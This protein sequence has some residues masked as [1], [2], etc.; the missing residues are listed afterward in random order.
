MTR[1]AAIVGWGMAVP[2]RVVTNADIEQLVDTSD[3]WIRA[4]TGIAERRIA[5][6]GVPTSA[7]ASAAGREALERAGVS[8]ESVDLVVLAT[9]TPDRLFP[10]TASTVQASLGLPNAGAFD[11]VAACSGFVYGLSVA[12]SMVQSGAHETVLLVGVDLFSHILDWQDRN[13]CILFG[14][15]AGA[16]V[17]QASTMSEGLLAS[18]VGSDGTH[19]DLMLIEAGGTRKPMTPDDLEARRN[20]F[21]MNGREVF[22]HAVRGMAE[23]SL[24]ALEKAGL[25][26][27]E[28]DLIVPHQANVR[29]ID[30]LAKR[31]SFPLERVFVNIEH[32]GNT[33]AASVPIA[34]CDAVEQGRLHDGD[35]VLL[36]AFG[37]GLAWASAVVRW[38]HRGVPPA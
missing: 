31:L 21:F 16:V 8:P 17:L 3:E 19:E 25:S 28:V 18:V 32:Y 20:C 23:S 34:L 14:D 22:K 24:Q 5:E 29:I 4:R 33:S 36:T 38:G 1:Y 26:K 10:A 2:E 11:L 6:E 9:C 13:T 30:S 15:G 12:T 7:L 27:D 35:T 37:G